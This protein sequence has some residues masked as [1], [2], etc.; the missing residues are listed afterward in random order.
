MATIWFGF[1]ATGRVYKI[2]NRHIE[3]PKM[4]FDKF[5]AW[6]QPPYKSDQAYDKRFVHALLFAL[7]EDEVIR[8]NEVPVDVIDFIRGMK[9]FDFNFAFLNCFS[10]VFIFSII[11][12]ELLNKRCDY[13]PQR[14]GF[15]DRYIDELC[16][17]SQ[18]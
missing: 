10:S 11:F 5:I 9:L 1:Q 17:K 15:L 6:N 7:V 16:R 4:I 3:V 8:K 12:P 2:G 18:N 14:I 13:D